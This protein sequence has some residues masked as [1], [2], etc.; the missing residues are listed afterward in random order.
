MWICADGHPAG[1]GEKSCPTCGAVVHRRC[2]VCQAYASDADRSCVACG[3]PLDDTPVAPASRS[4]FPQPGPGWQQAGQWGTGPWQAPPQAGHWQAPPA[5]RPGPWQSG[6]WSAGPR[7]LFGAPLSGWW[8]RVGAM[9]LD[10]LVL[11]VPVAVLEAVV[12]GAVGGN[13]AGTAV[14]TAEGIAVPLV[15]LVVQGIYFSLLNG[16]GRGQTIG[17]MVAG[18]AVRDLRSGAVIGAGR[19]TLRWLVRYL[20]YLFVIPGLLSDLWPLWDNQQQT[21]ADKAANTVMV[22]VR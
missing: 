3:T 11:V 7:A 12:L 13:N 5:L 16:L 8:P 14:T 4:P 10:V 21:W 1:A 22:R 9:V 15:V 17:N 2:A 6:P 20:L 19:G 18:I